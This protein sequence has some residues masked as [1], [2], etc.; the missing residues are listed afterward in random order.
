M[1]DLGRVNKDKTRK[2]ETDRRIGV[3]GIRENENGEEKGSQKWKWRNE[4]KGKGDNDE[5]K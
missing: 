4:T 5:S 3:K 2:R 1:G